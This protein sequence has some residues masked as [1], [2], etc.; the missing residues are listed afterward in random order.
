M[1]TTDLTDDGAAAGCRRL[2]YGRPATRDRGDRGLRRTSA[3]RRGVGRTFAH[4]LAKAPSLGIRTLASPARTMRR[5][6]RCSSGQDSLPG[7][8]AAGLSSMAS[9]VT[10]D[11]RAEDC[12]ILDFFR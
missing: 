1:G 4:A 9:S 6:S 11:P 7:S 8:P 3:Q 12:V 10:C 5:P 2:P